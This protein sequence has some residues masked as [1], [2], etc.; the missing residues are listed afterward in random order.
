MNKR[1]NI[2]QAALQL[3]SEQGFHAAPVS[4][5]AEQAK[6]GAGTVYRYFKNKEDLLN[7][8]YL[9][10]KSRVHEAMNEGINPEMPLEALFKRLWLNTFEFDIKHPQEF[11]FVEQYCDSPFLTDLTR[12]AEAKVLQNH[13]ETFER[14]VQDGVV[15]DLPVE[16]VFSIFSGSI[17]SLAKKHLA[18]VLEMTEERRQQAAHATWCAIR[19]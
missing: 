17:A 14:G 19:K 7:Q 16:M 9:E 4:Q 5:I 2:L 11:S 3:I 8:L 15:Q 18:G 1:T 6:V 13:K 10:I 12:A